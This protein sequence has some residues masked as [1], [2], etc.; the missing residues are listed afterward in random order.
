[1]SAGEFSI[2]DTAKLSFSDAKNMARDV[3]NV[4]VDII[5]EKKNFSQQQAAD[6]VKSKVFLQRLVLIY[7]STSK[8]GAI[9]RRRLELTYLFLYK[10]NNKLIFIY[11]YVI[12]KENKVTKF[13]DSFFFIETKGVTAENG[14]RYR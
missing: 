2:Q 5:A 9:S 7:P 14:R 4:I 3:N 12:P 11:A 8:Q 1:M 6:Y 10:C 13:Y